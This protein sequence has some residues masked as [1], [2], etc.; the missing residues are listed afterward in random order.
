MGTCFHVPNFL[1]LKKTGDSSPIYLIFLFFAD[2]L[3]NSLWDIYLAI[4]LPY[5]FPLRRIFIFEIELLRKSE[6][7]VKI[8]L[9]N[10][11][12]STKLSG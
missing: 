7:I 5:L 4:V 11:P 10:S 2:A 3:E 9:E 12:L 1:P 6:E 8:S